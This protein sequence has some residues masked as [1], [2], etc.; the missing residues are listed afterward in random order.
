[1]DLLLENYYNSLP[2]WFGWPK[3]HKKKFKTI[4]LEAAHIVSGPGTQLCS[5]QKLLR[6]LNWFGFDQLSFYTTATIVHRVKNSGEP[7]YLFNILIKKY[8]TEKRSQH[9]GNIKVGNKCPKSKLS[10][11]S[12]RHWAVLSYNKLPENVKTAPA[13]LT[14]KKRIKNYMKQYIPY[15]VDWSNVI[16]PIKSIEAVW[17]PL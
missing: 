9:F 3:Y 4:I 12:F 6:N 11:S 10:A 13:L 1:M 5:T 16:S 8:E 15:K 2:L 17:D 14:F 7:K